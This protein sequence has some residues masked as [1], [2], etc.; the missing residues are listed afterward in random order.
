V[1][2]ESDPGIK[3]KEQRLHFSS[4]FLEIAI[5]IMAIA[6]FVYLLRPA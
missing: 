4:I 5:G 6:I 1:R 2:D 3:K